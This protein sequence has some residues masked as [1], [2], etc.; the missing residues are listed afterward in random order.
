MTV[1]NQA[2]TDSVSMFTAI[3][4]AVSFILGSVTAVFA[5]PIRQRFFRPILKLSFS[6]AED[7][8][9]RTGTVAGHNAVYVRAKVVNQKRTLARRC[10]AF[11]V[12]VEQLNTRN[13]FEPTIYAD[14]IQLA[15]SCREQGTQ[16]DAIDLPH[17]V[18]QYV[19]VVATDQQLQNFLPQ[20]SPLPIR[21][22]DL[23]D[24][25]LKT[26]RFTV[27]VSGDGVDPE[28]IRIVF[29]WKGNWDSFDVYHDAV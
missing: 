4:W 28:F 29:V 22:K 3:G 9:A 27:Q 15:W 6:N 14:S 21:Y 7:C 5:E 19:D 8:V 20:I 17:G 25:T 11:L 24:V 26:L 10:R 18:S 16:R 12:N 1:E 13:V 23:F 2:T